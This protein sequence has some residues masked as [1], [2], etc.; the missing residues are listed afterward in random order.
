MLK[1]TL[2]A[3]R[4]NAGYTQK[5]AAQMLKI[6]NGTLGKWENGETFPSADKIND[7]CELYGVGYDHLNFLPK[8]SLK[9]NTEGGI[10]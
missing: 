8:R 6:S 3:A 10:A 5:E 9:A 4:V 1:I 7:I 2:E